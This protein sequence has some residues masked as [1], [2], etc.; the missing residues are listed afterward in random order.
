MKARVLT[1]AALLA[2]SGSAAAQSMSLTL[3]NAP[4]SDDITAGD[5][6]NYPIDVNMKASGFECAEPVDVP[7]N[8][9][10]VANAQ[11]APTNASHTPQPASLTFTIPEG[12]Y[13]PTGTPVD[14]QTGGEY[15]ET[16]SAEVGM[17]TASGVRQNYTVTLEITAES[18]GLSSESCN[19]D[20]PEAT[21]DPA[22]VE[23]NVTADDPPEPAGGDEDGGTGP[24]TT[25]GGGN[26][27]GNET[28]DEGNGIPAPTALVPLAVFGAAVAYRRR[29]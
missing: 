17:E 20:I 8:L 23:I 7:V 9:T 12:I 21:S 26:T 25:P 24:G 19:G 2:L 10:A 13:Q 16:Q 28:G 5:S 27:T 15:N 29:D 6:V 11:A 22:A 18:P 1:I 3:K 4:T 14:N